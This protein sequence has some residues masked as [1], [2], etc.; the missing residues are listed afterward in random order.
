[1]A[2]IFREVDEELRQ[3]QYARLWRKYSRYVYLAVFL[4]VAAVAGREGWTYY[5]TQQLEGDSRRFQ[6][7]LALA[8]AGRKE[9]AIEALAR[10]ADGASAGYQV[11]ARL[12][13]AALL[14]EAG[15]KARAV[16]AYET[17][18][19]DRGVDRL[20]RELAVLLLVLSQVDDG[21]ASA[22]EARVAPLVKPDDPWR[23]SALEI[24]A[25]LAE[26]QGQR[27]RAVGLL[28]QL[29]DDGEAPDGT[30]ARAA[31]LLKALGA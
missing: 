30:R 2:D 19:E 13:Q 28:K 9:A 21:D 1:M 7:A 17:I 27:E 4:I 31:E 10:L 15:A 18:A 3:E 24:Q 5:R 26:R 8:Q 29:V 14:L 20:Y 11:L 16:E 12:R 23:H 6:E 25:L 22:L